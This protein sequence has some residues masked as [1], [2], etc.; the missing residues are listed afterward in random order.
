[1]SNTRHIHARCS[2]RGIKQSM[3]DLVKEFGTLSGNG[4]K[5]VL[6]RKGIDQVLKTLNALKQDLMA[7]SNRGGYVLI[8]DHG[9]DITVY[10]LDSFK[11]G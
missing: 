8:S 10:A 6:N 9:T 7:A 2:Q 1:M 3:L 5:I 11:R 4:E